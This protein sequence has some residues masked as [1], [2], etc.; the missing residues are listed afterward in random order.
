MKISF[1]SDENASI[2]IIFG[3]SK[4]D[5]FAFSAP[6]AKFDDNCGNKISQAAKAANYKG[7]A[8]SVLTIH[9]PIDGFATCVLVGLGDL[10]KV[11]AEAIEKASAAAVKSVLTHGAK[12]AAILVQGFGENDVQFAASA[13]LGAK[14]ASYRFDKYRTKLKDSQKVA[15]EEVSIDVAEAASLYSQ[16]DA[17][18]DGV[19]LARDLMNEPP[20]VL[21]TN[22]FANRLKELSS[23]GVEV[24][25]IDAAKMAELKMFS[26]L[27]VGQGSV[28]PPQIAVMKYNGGGDEAP[29]AWW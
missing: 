7:G 5:E 22:E 20:N 21:T 17:I 11:N 1:K 6:A 28:N 15:L 13:G 14:L 8:N 4:N 19:Y 9:A 16:Y 3:G 10:D 26:F 25:I 18:A 29:V 27:G 12:S 2:Q 23:L 24:E